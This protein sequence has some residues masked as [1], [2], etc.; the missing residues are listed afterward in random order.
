MASKAMTI[1]ELLETERA[2][3]H[4]AEAKAEAD[5]HKAEADRH[6]AEADGQKAEA[7]AEADRQKAEA[8]A[9]ADRQNADARLAEIKELLETER[10]AKEALEEQ[11][12]YELSSI[13]VEQWNSL[14]DHDRSLNENLCK[15]YGIAFPNMQESSDPDSTEQDGER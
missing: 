4:K 9:E 3:R 2:D 6:K 14:N 10:A 1:K 8:K 13:T 5:R 7:K 12:R 11:L 15:Q